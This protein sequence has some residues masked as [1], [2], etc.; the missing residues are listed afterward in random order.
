VQRVVLDTNIVLS[1][2]LTNFGPAAVVLGL[3]L[4]RRLA[5]AIDEQILDEYDEVLSRPRFGIAARDRVIILDRIRRVG[6]A[7]APQVLPG[8]RKG[9]PDPSDVVFLELALGARVDALIT[10]NLK[11]FPPAR[12]GNIAILTPEQILARIQI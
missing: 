8:G 5:F 4:G 9:F 6:E 11:H 2:M 12:C 1:A 10:R 7:H 3:A